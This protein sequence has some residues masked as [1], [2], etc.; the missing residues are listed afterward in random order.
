MLGTDHLSATEGCVSG[1]ETEDASAT[2]TDTRGRLCHAA[3]AGSVETQGH[4]SD[5]EDRRSGCS[6]S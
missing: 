1:K 5:P 6:C 4:Q 2:R 3:R